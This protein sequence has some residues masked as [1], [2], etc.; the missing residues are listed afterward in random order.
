DL[1][2]VR[3]VIERRE[4]VD[5]ADREPYERE[6]DELAHPREKLVAV[7]R[8]GKA[9]DGECDPA[10]PD[11]EADEGPP[12]IAQVNVSERGADKEPARHKRQPRH[13]VTIA[14]RGVSD[15][16]CESESGCDG[17]ERTR[18]GVGPRSI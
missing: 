7:P 16:E 18:K 6:P 15:S 13:R 8:G 9:G 4:A 3:R 5:G 10:A 12:L 14:V 2:L 11:A 17:E 1:A